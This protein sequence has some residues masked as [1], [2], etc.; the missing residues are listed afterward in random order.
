M[1]QIVYKTLGTCSQ[2]IELEADENQVI[3]RLNVIGGCHG[4]LQGISR[5]VQGRKLSDVEKQLAGIQCGTKPTS[6][7]DQISR[8]IHELL[9]QY[10]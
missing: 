8:A 5:L 4:N 1:K 3:T 6:C 9:K 7:P 10:E 2:F